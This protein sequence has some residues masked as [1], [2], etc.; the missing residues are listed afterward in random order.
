[1][2]LA[3]VCPNFPP[4]TFEGGI[5]HYSKLLAE[6][7]AACGHEVFAIASTEFINDEKASGSCSTINCIPVK[8]PWG[9]RAALEIKKIA[10]RMK[11]TALILQYAPASFR[12]SFRV[13]WALSSYSCA[14]VTVFHT[15]WGG[16]LDRLWGLMMLAG[17]S[18]IIA[19]NSEIISIIER[20]LPWLLG[21]TYWIPIASNIVPR[22]AGQ[23]EASP[24]P[25][26]ITYFGM[27]YPG[28]GL[29]LILDTLQKLAEKN[30]RFQFKF[31]GGK[32]IHYQ[33]YEAQFLEKVASRGL[34]GVVEYLGFLPPREVSSWLNRSRFVFLPYERG[35]SDRRGSLMAALAHGKPVLSTHPV[36]PMPFFI[37]NRNILWPRETGI[38]ELTGL[39][40][41]LLRDDQLV[42]KL[43]AGARELAAKFTWEKIAADH[44]TLL[45]RCRLAQ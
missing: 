5:S 16:G 12:R 39:A 38:A 14:K 1:M 21:K 31:I 40:E 13:Q 41:R 43:Q 34:N 23:H 3:I 10:K 30:C 9:R 44:A 18:K 29:D 42:A 33:D 20:R 8:G 4:A 19:T 25:P 35:L 26:V 22:S 45:S 17:C 15:L 11:F 27:L 7:L 37:N 24:S 36:A 28:K 2:R 6:R 32:I